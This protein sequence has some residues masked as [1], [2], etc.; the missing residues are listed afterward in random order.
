M[1]IGR[2]S[3]GHSEAPGDLSEASVWLQMHTLGPLALLRIGW[4]V[5]WVVSKYFL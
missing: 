3:G 2:P 4:S 1:A 5:T